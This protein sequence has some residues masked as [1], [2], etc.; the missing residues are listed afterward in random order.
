MTGTSKLRFVI[1]SERT[2]FLTVDGVTTCLEPGVV[3]KCQWPLAV[4]ALFRHGVTVSRLPD[5]E[6]EHCEGE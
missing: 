4:K 1:T 3:V 5:E 6:D 2:V